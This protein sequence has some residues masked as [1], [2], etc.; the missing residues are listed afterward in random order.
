[1]STTQ[2][3][4][5]ALL[6]PLKEALTLAFW[7][8]KDLR[9]FLISCL[10][11]PGLVAGLDWSEGNFKRNIVRQLVETLSADQHRYFDQLVNLA[12]STA[13]ITDPYWLKG[14]EDGRRKYDEAVVALTALRALVEPLRRTRTEA[15][16]AARRQREEDARAALRRAI[17]EKLQELRELLYQITT[18]PPQER[19]YALVERLLN[20]LFM[21]FDIDTK[22][23]FKITGEQ[24]DGAFTLE[25]TEYLLEARWRSAKTSVADL[26]AFAGRIG[27]KLDNT[28][29]T[30]SPLTEPASVVS[31]G[32]GRPERRAW[33][34]HRLARSAVSQAPARRTHRRSLHQCLQPDHLRTAT[35]SSSV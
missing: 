35:T 29:G 32:R 16:K 12:L 33:G 26:N 7:F 20:E 14:V 22:S 31:D 10:D 5:P 18:L 11:D 4:S 25:G 19:G 34:P 6:P 28:L 30:D 8:K 17:S 27:R 21:L 24:I 2:R 15:D 3:V 9:P 23:A 13:D 1:M